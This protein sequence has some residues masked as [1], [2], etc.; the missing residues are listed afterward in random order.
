MNPLP[1][2]RGNLRMDCHPVL[3]G[4]SGG[5]LQARYPAMTSREEVCKHAAITLL[6]STLLYLHMNNRQHLLCD[7]QD[8]L[9]SRVLAQ[10]GRSAD[11]P[12]LVGMSR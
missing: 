4:Q 8:I 6:G 2:S 1:V 7:A 12:A 11:L 5:C 3:K 9:S 10:T